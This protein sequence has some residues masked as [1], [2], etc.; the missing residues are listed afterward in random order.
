[1]E[2]LTDE[3]APSPKAATREVSEEERKRDS[4]DE[5][6]EVVVDENPFEVTLGEALNAA[7]YGRR[8]SIGGWA[9]SRPAA[10][11]A[12]RRIVS[13]QQSELAADYAQAKERLRERRPDDDAARAGL[14]SQSLRSNPNE[15]HRQQKIYRGLYS[16][17]LALIG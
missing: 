7:M 9:K 10:G 17:A 2:K 11:C 5:K 1:M 15:A 16:G 3:G 6:Y 12:S 4:E 14:G 13:R 8:R